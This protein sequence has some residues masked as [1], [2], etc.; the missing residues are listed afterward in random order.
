MIIYCGL[1]GKAT[2]V[3][4]TIP[5]GTILDDVV[6]IAP[7]GAATTLLRVLPPTQEYLDDIYCVKSLETDGHVITKARL[8]E[9]VATIWGQAKYQVILKEAD[10]IDDDGKVTQYGKTAASFMGSFNVSRGIPPKYPDATDA[11]FGDEAKDEIDAYTKE[12]FYQA[13]ANVNKLF[14]A[15]EALADK[16]GDVSALDIEPDADGYKTIVAA[17]NQIKE[18]AEAAKETADETAETV[19]DENGGLVA[20]VASLAGT[21]N[22][23]AGAVG[24]ATAAAAAAEAAKEEAVSAYNQIDALLKE[25]VDAVDDLVGG[26][27]NGGED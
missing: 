5:M 4:A 1:D 12:D 19:G 13:F 11:D 14:D 21:V 9:E 17:F 18:I 15:Y 10:T 23:L 20:Q 16:L 27:E 3:P 2:S 22:G 8:P 6:I 24:T 25:Y 26:N 7:K